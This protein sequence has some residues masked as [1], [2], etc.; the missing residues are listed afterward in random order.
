[1]FTALVIV[2]TLILIGISLAVFASPAGAY[3]LPWLLAPC[4]LL[5]TYWKTRLRIGPLFT[6][7]E[8]NDQ[9]IFEGS[10][11]HFAQNSEPLITFGFKSQGVYFAE[12]SEGVGNCV[13][14][15]FS[16]APSSTFALLVTNQ[17]WRY[18]GF[19]RICLVTQKDKFLMTTPESTPLPHR[20]PFDWE[21]HLPSL[22]DPTDLWRA[23]Q[24]LL[25]VYTSSTVPLPDTMVEWCQLLDRDRD[26]TINEIVR[27]QLF[28]LDRSGTFAR[29][30]VN[31]TAR[32]VRDALRPWSLRRQQFILDREETILERCGLGGMLRAARAS[33]PARRQAGARPIDEFDERLPDD[34]G[35]RFDTATSDTLHRDERRTDPFLRSLVAKAERARGEAIPQHGPI[36]SEEFSR[37][38]LLANGLCASCLY[39]LTADTEESDGCIVCSECGA[40]WKRTRIQH[41]RS[42]GTP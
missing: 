24:K 5:L 21:W 39:S 23:H 42:F 35:K 19:K 25:D 3:V 30:T 11:V 31:G 26:K 40:A 12:K 4:L 9:R 13:M 41:F 6:P 27:S 16:H 29:P 36:G 32:M 38:P 14:Q 33:T 7:I 37:A 20:L 1:M 8:L 10:R 2:A 18:I 17:V 15:V 28:V 34:R 22:Y